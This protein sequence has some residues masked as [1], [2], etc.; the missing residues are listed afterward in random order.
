MTLRSLL[1][2]AVSL[3]LM[4]AACGSGDPVGVEGFET[5]TITIDVRELTV[6]VADKPALR[7]RG[8]MGVT[9]LGGLD[10]MLFVF[11]S[12]TEGGFWMKN[13]LIALDIAFFDDGGGFVDRFTMEPCI[14]DPC[15]GYRPSGPYRYAVEAPAGDLDF[16]TEGSV[17]E[18]ADD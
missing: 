1:M 17:L 15:P 8:L 13:T 18:L 2:L 10:G 11:Q 4:L 14:E 16:V 12:D 5:T 3:S 6:A 7:S 9:D